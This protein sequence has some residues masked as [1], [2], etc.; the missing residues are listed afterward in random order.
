MALTKL[1]S[2][3][4]PLI[5]VIIYYAS[6]FQITDLDTTIISNLLAELP[7]I[8]IIVWLMFKLNDQRR[9]ALEHNTQAFMQMIK[10]QREQHNLYVKEILALTNKEKAH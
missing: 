1:T 9:E 7:A 2:T 8:V 5:T 3:L 4:A 6:L 10:E